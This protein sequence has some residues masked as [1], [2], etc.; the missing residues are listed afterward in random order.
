M[1]Q[2]VGLPANSAMILEVSL[3][4]TLGSS[5]A[6]MPFTL[7]EQLAWRQFGRHMFVLELLPPRLH[8][9]GREPRLG[10]PLADHRCPASGGPKQLHSPAGSQ[11]QAQYFV[12]RW[13][14]ANLPA[15]QEECRDRA[16]CTWGMRPAAGDHPLPPGFDPAT[17]PARQKRRSRRKPPKL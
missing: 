16:V 8:R 4:E 15:I 5:I 11:R 1:R 2:G 13:T 9:G 7:P 3:I 14:A 6:S 12:G 17:V 10:R